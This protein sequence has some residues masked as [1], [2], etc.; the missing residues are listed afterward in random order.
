MLNIF[1]C[2]NTA[3]DFSGGVEQSDGSVC[4]VR[5]EEQDRVEQGKEE[6]C[7]QQMVNQCYNSYVTTY[8]DVVRERC[9]EIFIKTCRIILRERAFNATTRVCKR[10]LIKECNDPVT[11]SEAESLTDEGLSLGASLAIVW[12]VWSTSTSRKPTRAKHCVPESL[13][14]SVQ[15][16]TPGTAVRRGEMLTAPGP[17]DWRTLPACHQLRP[18]EEEDLRRGPLPGGGGRGGVP[19]QGGGQCCRGAGGD[20]Q[21]GPRG[22]VQE[23]DDQCTPGAARDLLHLLH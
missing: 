13:R 17:P 4:V 19:R 10:P 2:Q 8:K 9:Q 22:G 11:V 1:S 14:D 23:R 20:L 15:H 18:G 12:R 21:H 16:D 6:Q 3:I 5:E 7:T